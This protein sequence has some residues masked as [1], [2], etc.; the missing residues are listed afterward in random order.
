MLYYYSFIALLVAFVVHHVLRRRNAPP[1]PPGPPGLP[2][3]GN[4][5]E[6]PEKDEWVWYL[7]LSQRY[8]SDIISLRLLNETVI[9]LNS[10]RSAQDLL[11]TR[12]AIY[13]DRP[14]F[15]MLNDLVGFTWHLAFMP[16]NHTWK[17]Y[18]KMFTQEFLPSQIAVHRPIE[19]HAAHVLLQG[20][21]E[22]PD[23]Y[24]RHLRHMAAM[25]IL[26]T[27]YGIDV[28][29]QDDPHVDISTE[30]LHVMAL[31]GNRGS[32]LVDFL[33]ILQ[34]IPA[35]LPG[36]RFLRDAREWSRC[37]TSMPRVPFEAAKKRWAAGDL[38][39]CIAS[40]V[41]DEIQEL[42]ED[43]RQREEGVLRDV[44]SAGYAAGADTTVST[45]ASFILAMALYPEV[46][47]KAQA[48]V[49]HVVGRHRLPT[50]DD[51][52][53]YVDALLREALRW[54]PVTP[55][56]IVHATTAADTYNGYHIPAGA[57]VIGNSWA[58]LREE[59][60]YGAHTEQFIPERWLNP[61][62][63][64]NPAI[65][66]PTPAFGFGRR[67][68]PGKDMAQ[69]SVWICMISILATFDIRKPVDEQGREIQPSEEYTSGLVSCVG[70]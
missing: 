25:V 30:A 16:Y 51:Q 27:A 20:L 31:T 10:M 24:E 69:W 23:A 17:A 66:E 43:Q 18:R 56:A 68:C 40:R 59:A 55:L 33:P 15:R 28:K 70:V 34:H 46:Q 1:L 35:W 60:V 42:P 53:T 45:L 36:A 62:G 50:F 61:D 38:Q 54:H 22:S 29:P 5:F 19:L 49:D 41:L 4:W 67:V 3:I 26:T 6:I 57:S 52:V 63:S 13:S 48:A 14:A 64:L 65:P 32:Y 12:S 7:A 21:L 44:L 2:I 39:P 11:E 9:V 47:T 58:I 8:N 37:V